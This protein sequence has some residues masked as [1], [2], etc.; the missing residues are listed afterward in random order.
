MSQD[1]ALH[2]S[3]DHKKRFVTRT[4]SGIAPDYDLVNSIT[5]LLLD[6]Y[7]RYKTI[8]A[9]GPRLKGTLLDLCAGTLPL[10]LCALRAGAPRV[11][12]VDISM[13]MLA[14]GLKR[15]RWWRHKLFLLCAD[16]EAI[17]LAESSVD[18]VVVAF[19]IRNLS[20]MPRAFKE[21]QRVLRPGGR[22][23]IVE[24]SRPTL[25]LFS[26]LYRIYLRYFLVNVGGLLTGDREAYQYLVDSIY[27]FPP[28][29]HVCRLLSRAGFHGVEASPLTL[30]LVTLYTA[31][32]P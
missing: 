25:P 23:A 3:Q 29:S 16:G 10:A 20:H 1:K 32:N 17:P 31:C 2:I 28:P 18:G 12:A 5:S 24:F 27:K 13:Q 19:G 8:K 30:G 15:A 11:V 7:W 21:M 6:R 26:G 9:L 4:F 22:L 14:T